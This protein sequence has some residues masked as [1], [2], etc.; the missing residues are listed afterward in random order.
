M[1]WNKPQVGWV[2]INVDGSVAKESNI[3]SACGVAGCGGVIRDHY[4]HWISGSISKIGIYSIDEA[5]TWGVYHALRLAVKL[6]YHRVVLECDSKTTIDRLK[7]PS[8]DI[9]GFNNL[10]DRCRALM[11]HFQTIEVHHVYREQNG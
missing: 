9:R 5:E 11:S 2:T 4:G 10:F 8:R 7:S 6:G 1:A 3:E